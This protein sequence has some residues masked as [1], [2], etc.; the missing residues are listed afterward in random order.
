MGTVGIRAAGAGLAFL[1]SVILAR[2]LGSSGYG[3]YSYGV[4][5]AMVL[6]VI[7]KLGLPQLLLREVAAASAREKWSLVR[8]ILV[9]GEQAVWGGSLLV[10]VLAVT[11]IHLVPGWPEDDQI[12]TVLWAVGLVPVMALGAIRSGALRGLQRVVLGLIPQAL[13]RPGML[14][15]LVSLAYVAAESNVDSALAMG[16]HVT[17]GAIAFFVAT[18]WLIRNLPEGVHRERSTDRLG[19][20]SRAA[21]PFFLL[22]VVQTVNGQVD[23]LMLGTLRPADE[24]GIY[25][26]ALAIGS[27]VP[28]FLGA[29]NVVIE[30][31]VS[32]LYSGEDRTTLQRLITTEA[33]WVL[34]MTGPIVVLLL[35]FGG[36][37]LH[38]VYGG[39]YEAGYD[40]LAIIAVGQLANVGMGPVV[41]VLNMTG[42][43]RESLQGVS[44]A[45]VY[46]VV[47]NAALIPVLGAIG[48]ALAH[49]TSLVVWNGYLVYRLRVQL[50]IDSTALGLV[51]GSRSR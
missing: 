19:E 47:A 12:A 41:L 6:A 29:A 1:S 30:P 21:A 9:R 50:G 40:P 5:V 27:L 18:W 20:W 28:F 51:P 39:Q 8:G 45:A 43:Q 13:L 15:I 37:F 25:R 17:A 7:A 26:V 23:I 36:E 42:H 4:S 10:G 3:I 38:V 11:V 46:N 48:A 34:L 22:G 44:L 16:L 31:E 2:I 49:A 35:V 32:R 14:I 33:R 24:L